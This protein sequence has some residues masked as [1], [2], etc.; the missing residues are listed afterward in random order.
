MNED[1]PSAYWSDSNDLSDRMFQTGFP[2]NYENWLK[3]TKEFEERTSRQDHSKPCSILDTI[4][5]GQNQD[6]FYHDNDPRDPSENTQSKKA[7]SSGDRARNS[8]SKQMFPRNSKYT[9]VQP[10]KRPAA[11]SERKKQSKEDSDHDSMADGEDDDNDDGQKSLD[12]GDD[13]D[14]EMDDGHGE[15][16]GRKSNGKAAPTKV[17]LKAKNREHA[18][19]TR[20]RKKNYIE[21][22]KDDIKFLTQDREKRDRERKMQLS[23]LAEQVQTRKKVLQSMFDYRTQGELSYEKWAAILEEEFSLVLPVTPYRSFPPHEVIDDQRHIRGVQAVI[24]DSASLHA[25]LQS[26][27]G[28]QEDLT[29]ML[30]EGDDEE[31]QQPPHSGKQQQQ[32]PK[33]KPAGRRY[34]NSAAGT[35]ATSTTG[36]STTVS[37]SSSYYNNNNSTTS[38]TKEPEPVRIQYII[39]PDESV[40]SDELFM[41]KWQ[42]TTTNAIDHGCRYEISKQGMMKVVFSEQNRLS[43][44]EMS[45]DVMSFMQQLRRAS[46]NFEFLVIPNTPLLAQ[47]AGDTMRIVVDVEAPY[48][49]KSASAK[50]LD[51][52]KFRANKLKSQPLSVLFA[53]DAENQEKYKSVIALLERNLPCTAN[54]VLTVARGDLAVVKEERN[55]VLLANK[56]AGDGAAGS[57]GYGSVT[58]ASGNTSH[59]TSSVLSSTMS[60]GRSGSSSSSNSS[61]SHNNDR[62]SNTSSSSSP[63]FVASSAPS[64]IRCATAMY[65]LYS[66]GR[67]SHFMLSFEVFPSDLQQGFPDAICASET[68][69]G[70]GSGSDIATAGLGN[71]DENIEGDQYASAQH[72]NLA[73]KKRPTFADPLDN[74]NSN[75]SNSRNASSL[76]IGNSSNS[77]RTD[78]RSSVSGISTGSNN[79]SEDGSFKRR[80]LRQGFNASMSGMSGMEMSAIASNNSDVDN[81]SALPGM[82]LLDD[83][84]AASSG[85]GL[86]GLEVGCSAADT[87]GASDS[88]NMPLLDISGATSIVDITS[89]A[90]MM[91]AESTATSR[92]HKQNGEPK[93]TNENL[94]S[95]ASALQGHPS[96]HI[97]ITSAANTSANKMTN[98]NSCTSTS[99][100]N[101]R[102]G[103]GTNNNNNNNNSNNDNNINKNNSNIDGNI[104]SNNDGHRIQHSTSVSA[105]SMDSTNSAQSRGKPSL[106]VNT[107]GGGHSA[108]KNSRHSNGETDSASAISS[109]ITASHASH[110]LEEQSGSGSGSGSNHSPHSRDSSEENNIIAGKNADGTCAMLVEEEDENISTGSGSG[111]STGSGNNTSRTSKD[112]KS[113]QH[114]SNKEEDNSRSSITNSNNGSDKAA[115]GKKMKAAVASPSAT[116]KSNEGIDGKDDDDDEEM[117]ASKKQRIG[118][119]AVEK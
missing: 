27:V 8:N 59:E 55:D 60:N 78:R 38:G 18:K 40:M 32:Q 96:T 63:S 57:N 26:L 35:A 119:T 77:S 87:A 109:T 99:L 113:S 42:L 20:M 36:G 80:I 71:E 106:A 114:S 46:G 34:A 51:L 105:E 115:D 43:H 89:G 101:S 14:E 68:S 75:S 118:S 112:D 91:D 107:T 23:Q 92:N 73:S 4:G 94:K 79:S 53:K 90:P 111:S 56:R 31:D 2:D 117:P 74:R 70:S 65:P 98:N 9:S 58:D 47:D 48:A 85:L 12:D 3:E 39:G 15:G 49:I 1:G 66:E 67:V 44:L 76:K 19:N 21:A 103:L 72:A 22:L 50:F 108:R 86:L 82:S 37:S 30:A 45:F 24:Q 16:S 25:M 102:S 61:G 64:K 52:F 83:G 6:N 54:L 81:V 10:H 110:T 84:T 100:I 69:G 17:N 62:I 41:C 11:S 5:N 95:N 88:A 28:P 104:S 116:S 33:H 29:E 7:N 93:L 97:Q 13:A